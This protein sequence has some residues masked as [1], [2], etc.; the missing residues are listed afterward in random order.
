MI[1]IFQTTNKPFNLVCFRFKGNDEQNMAVM[2][3]V[4][5]TGKAYFT[6]TK[7]SGKVVLRLSV[8]QT[9]TE[10]KHVE[11]VW[12]MIKKTSENL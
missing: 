9:N 12:K 5:E 6:H 10:L 2:N 7:L 3:S 4:N 1:N 11:E 8:G